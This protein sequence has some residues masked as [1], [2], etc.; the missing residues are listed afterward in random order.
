MQSLRGVQRPPYD[1][2]QGP[3]DRGVPRKG[4][5]VREE[6]KESA[7]LRVQREILQGEWIEMKCHKCGELLMEIYE[8][9][10]EVAY[11]C[12]HCEI[13][14][15]WVKAPVGVDEEDEWEEEQ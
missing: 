2:V 3:D 15:K 5:V 7:V 12:P 11:Y 10:G 14:F 4:L 9:T 6:W 13:V 1:Q 8:A